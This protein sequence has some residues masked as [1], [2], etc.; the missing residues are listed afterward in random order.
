MCTYN[1]LMRSGQTY[2]QGQFGRLVDNTG[3]PLLEGGVPYISNDPGAHAQTGAM[4]SGYAM[5]HV[6][7]GLL[8]A[9]CCMLMTPTQWL[10]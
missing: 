2:G 4:L 3:T 5:L 1:S 10:K 7:Q 9:Y 6:A 8:H